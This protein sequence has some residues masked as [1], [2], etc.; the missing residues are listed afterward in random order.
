MSKPGKNKWDRFGLKPIEQ[1]VKPDSKGVKPTQGANN[2]K[3]PQG[4]SGQSNRTK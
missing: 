2:P 3:P 4:G 1:A